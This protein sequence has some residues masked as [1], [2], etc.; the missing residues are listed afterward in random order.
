MVWRETVVMLVLSHPSLPGSCS[1][2]HL[3]VPLW[4]LSLILGPLAT[5]PLCC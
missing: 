5:S 2:R 4:T 3:Y 1:S